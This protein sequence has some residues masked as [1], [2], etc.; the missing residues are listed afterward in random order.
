MGF[1]NAHEFMVKTPDAPVPVMPAL[2]PVVE[3]FAL[4]LISDLST[5][6]EQA[7]ALNGRIVFNQRE[8]LALGVKIEHVRDSIAKLEIALRGQIASAKSEDNKPLYSN[9]EKR[10]AEFSRQSA[11]HQPYLALIVGLSDLKIKQAEHQV[12]LDSMLRLWPLAVEM[13]TVASRSTLSANPVGFEMTTTPH[14]GL[15]LV[16]APHPSLG[17]SPLKNVYALWPG[18]EP[19]DSINERTG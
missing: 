1:T 8:I 3:A 13:V 11:Q 16:T 9:E 10:Q 14:L 12:E 19:V 4:Q 18:K 15:N 6:F 2:E 5:A 7:Q 17:V